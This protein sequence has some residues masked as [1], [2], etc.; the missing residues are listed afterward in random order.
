MQYPKDTS[1]RERLL[2]NAK[3]PEFPLELPKGESDLSTFIWKRDVNPLQLILP[4][5]FHNRVRFREKRSRRGNW[6]MAPFYYTLDRYSTD[7]FIGMRRLLDTQKKE[8]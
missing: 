5:Q 6:Y 7:Y 1:V 2:S 3:R 4:T 8:V